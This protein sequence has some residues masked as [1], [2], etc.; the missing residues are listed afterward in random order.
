MS[1]AKSRTMSRDHKSM[2]SPMCHS[3]ASTRRAT[4]L[5]AVSIAAACSGQAPFVPLTPDLLR[6]VEPGRPA[7]QKGQTATL[8]PT[9]QWLLVGGEDA[10]RPTAAATL[11][12]AT[13]SQPVPI[14]SLTHARSGHTATVL[15]DG[16]VLVLGGWNADGRV[17]T[18]A[19][20]FDPM[21][22]KFTERPGMERLARAEHTATLLTDGQLLVVGGAMAQPEARSDAVFWNSFSQET[23]SARDSFLERPRRQHSAVLLPGGGVLIHGGL[24][25][26]G[27]TVAEAEIFE[28]RT[29]RFVRFDEE[30]RSK[31]PA[32][33]VEAR[34]P[35]AEEGVIAGVPERLEYV[36][37]VRFSKPVNP[38]S[39]SEKTVTVI[40]PSGAGAVRPVVA[41]RGMLLFVRAVNK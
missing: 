23:Q 29:R 5:A 33:S 35:R 40:G 4:L 30:Q 22:R 27:N 12:D 37:A 19:E 9:G 2:E 32:D 6:A 18:R 38:K 13:T 24:D 36:P 31:L 16:T 28:P 25:A 14:D 15:P 8:L 34:E 41:E 20:V 21:S 11:L 26:E 39:L 1:V 17:E 7:A 10:G 3:G